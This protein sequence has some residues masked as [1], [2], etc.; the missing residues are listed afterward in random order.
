MKSLLKKIGKKKIII[1]SLILLAFILVSSPLFSKYRLLVVNQISYLLM[2]KKSSGEIG[3]GSASIGEDASNL[4]IGKLGEISVSAS[5]VAP[6]EENSNLSDEFQVLAPEQEQAEQVAEKQDTGTSNYDEQCDLKETEN[7]KIYSFVSYG[8]DASKSALLHWISEGGEDDYVCLR[9]GDESRFKKII[10]GE[11]VI[12]GL[13]HTLALGD[14]APGT[15]Y[16]YRIISENGMKEGTFRTGYLGR[17]GFHFVFLGH[18]REN[19]F[20]VSENDDAYFDKE[21]LYAE[22]IS[23]IIKHKEIDFVL[24]GG[25]MTRNSTLLEIKR[26]IFKQFDGLIEKYPFM[27][28]RGNHEA[29]EFIQKLLGHDSF[30]SFNYQGVYFLSIDTNRIFDAAKKAWVKRKLKRARGKSELIVV[31]SHHNPYIIHSG[32]RPEELKDYLDDIFSETRPDLVLAGDGNAYERHIVDGI[33][34]VSVGQGAA[35]FQAGNNTPEK[36]YNYDE[37]QTSKILDDGMYDITGQYYLLVAV[38]G[39][40]LELRAY[41]GKEEIIDEYSIRPCSPKE[42]SKDNWCKEQYDNDTQ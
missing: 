9:N 27:I 1:S 40:S 38:K 7:N 29:I 13:F 23:N 21:P 26:D 14:L 16:D 18:T 5:F 39:N 31:Y 32:P 8:R 36:Y 20:P 34:H 17:G 19:D 37:G 25:D 2:E 35:I 42:P 15:D 33:T 12:D 10:R 22:M 6:E 30:Y 11:S 24:H 28:T 3:S 4:E 41:N